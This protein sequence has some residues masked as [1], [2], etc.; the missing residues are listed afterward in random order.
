MRHRPYHNQGLPASPL[1]G[2]GTPGHADSKHTQ[3]GL[4]SATRHRCATA[5]RAGRLRAMEKFDHR[6]AGTKNIKATGW[7]N[8]RKDH[9]LTGRTK[10]RPIKRSKT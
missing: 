4:L 6:P 3:P 5:H 10:K 7:E 1:Q 9:R 2:T 8:K